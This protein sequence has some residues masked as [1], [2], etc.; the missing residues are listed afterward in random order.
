M[1]E[2]T[3]DPVMEA[4]WPWWQPAKGPSPDNTGRRAA[5]Q[6]GVLAAIGAGLFFG[7]GHRTMGGVIWAMGALI[8]CSGLWA[9]RVFKAIERLGQRMGAGTTEL[10]VLRARPGVDPRWI[11]YAVRSGHFLQEGVTAF[12]GVADLA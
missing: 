9:P 10:H 11:C 7:L 1:N 2:K 6:A 8:G 3:S 5:I 12:E 4:V